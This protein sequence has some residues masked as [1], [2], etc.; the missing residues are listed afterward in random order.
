MDGATA[1]SGGT[2]VFAKYSVGSDSSNHGEETCPPAGYTSVGSAPTSSESFEVTQVAG[3][4][5]DSNTMHNYRFA[6]CAYR[7]VG[8]AKHYLGKYVQGDCLTG[9]CGGTDHFGWAASTQDWSG[10]GGA[11]DFALNMGG[12]SQRLLSVDSVTDDYTSMTVADASYYYASGEVMLIV[13]GASSNS[14]CGTYNGQNIDVGMT[15]LAR[16]LYSSGSTIKIARGTFAD[17][18]TS[19]SLNNSTDS[20]SFC[21]VQV[22]QVPHFH[23]INL[24]GR[25]LGTQTFDY[26]FSGGGIIAL[27]ANGTL[28]LGGSGDGINVGGRGY[29]SGA[30]TIPNGAGERRAPSATAVSDIGGEGDGGGGGLGNGGGGS[31]ANGG[32]GMAPTLGGG[33]LRMLFGGGGASVGPPNQGNG[34]GIIAVVAQKVISNSGALWADGNPG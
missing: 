21:Y 22:I 24:T 6:A 9:S 15:G 12:F 28:N 16:L 32:S 29:P 18:L 3:V 34:G 25:A 13:N 8:G 10:P 4:P 26:G 30:N 11:L 19:T 7:T 33:S 17:V 23:N 1:Y 2:E 27:R 5:L 31:S 14:Y 20:A